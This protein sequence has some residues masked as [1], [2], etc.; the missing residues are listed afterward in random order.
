MSSADAIISQASGYVSAMK[1]AADK[2]ASAV[3]ISVVSSPVKP[4]EF[5]GGELNN[6]VSMLR[7]L[8]ADTKTL[9]QAVLNDI[10]RDPTALA[11]PMP[12]AP[13]R[14]S[15]TVP[16]A[17]T[18]DAAPNMIAVDTNVSLP[19]AKSFAIPT[20][21]ILTAPVMPSAPTFSMPAAPTLSQIT[22]PSPPVVQL[23]TFDFN[24]QHREL[25]LL[26]LNLPDGYNE[27]E[28]WASEQ[29]TLLM[30][31]INEGI[32]A[33]P[34]PGNEEQALYDRARTRL[35]DGYNDQR[36]DTSRRFAALNYPAP[37]GAQLAALGRLGEKEA[38]ELTALNAEIM[39][40]QLDKR[41]EYRKFL[42]TLLKDLDA[43]VQ[44]WV[45]GVRARTMDN[46]L[47]LANAKVAQYNANIQV[48]QL[49]LEQYRTEASVFS[50]RIRAAGFALEVYKTQLEGAKLRGELNQMDVEIYKAMLGAQEAVQQVYATQVQAVESVVRTQ[51]AQVDIYRAS[52]DGVK[53]NIEAYQAELGAAEV[54]ARVIGAV[55]QANAVAAD[56]YKT[57]QS[58]KMAAYEGALQQHEAQVKQAGYDQQNYVNQVEAFRAKL[59]AVSEMM[60]A[61]KARAG[62]ITESSRA[63]VD[64]LSA[65]ADAAGKSADLQYRVHASNNELI[66]RAN[67]SFSDYAMKKAAAVAATAQVQAQAASSA[68][69]VI[70]N[71]ASDINVNVTEGA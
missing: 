53:A 2:M 38:I 33:S 59:A 34:L 18:V 71:L 58:V 1:T 15:F 43:S 48:I 50:E 60:D 69:G 67:E 39:N 45:S 7:N 3:N 65:M 52:V 42:M 40:T 24:Y 22:V 6:I 63:M 5:N 9:A 14:P 37:P 62:I 19:A 21:P 8:S 31:K 29:F 11:G 61:H 49:G 4:I 23:P 35:A 68:L 51:L 55:T 32:S 46:L 56:I 20:A 70:G 64:A 47:K 28:A 25:P 12:T 44:Q 57:Q 30:A 13:M 36:S 26:A 66:S 27:S 10:P 16:N 17:P 41:I 54:K